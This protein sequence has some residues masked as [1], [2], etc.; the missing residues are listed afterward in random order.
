MVR[1]G[2]CMKRPA[3]EVSETLRPSVRDPEATIAREKSERE[4]EEEGPLAGG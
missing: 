1:A 2:H 4:L 3:L